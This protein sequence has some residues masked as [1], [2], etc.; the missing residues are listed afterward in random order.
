M[1]RRVLPVRLM[2]KDERPEDR[3]DFTQRDLLSHVTAIRAG[4][5]VRIVRVMQAYLQAGR[6]VQAGRQ[7]G[8]FL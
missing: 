8:G 3:D 4:L 1:V 2:S 7:W 5:V 6:P